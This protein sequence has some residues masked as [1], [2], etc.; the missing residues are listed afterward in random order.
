M[1]LRGSEKEV[2]ERANEKKRKEEYVKRKIE[3]KRQIGRT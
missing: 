1:R 3:E 2:N